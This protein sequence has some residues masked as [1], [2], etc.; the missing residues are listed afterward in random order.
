MRVAI[1]IKKHEILYSTGQNLPVTL[2]HKDLPCQ[3]IFL[4]K[5]VH[6]LVKGE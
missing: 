6:E 2:Q 3:L 5:N 1:S 4:G